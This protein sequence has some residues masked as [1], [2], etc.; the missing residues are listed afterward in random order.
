MKWP[1]NMP[2]WHADFAKCPER[3]TGWI[4][5]ETLE[6]EFDLKAD[7]LVSQNTLQQ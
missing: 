5:A 3:E 7:T 2:L 6:E 1:W 4:K